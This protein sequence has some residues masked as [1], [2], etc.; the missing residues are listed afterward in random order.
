MLLIAILT[1][2][3]SRKSNLNI[4]EYRSA[5][6][7]KIDTNTVVSDSSKIQLKNKKSIKEETKKN[8]NNGDIVIKGKTD[9]T[10][11]FRFHNVVDGDTLSEIFIHGNADFV[12]KNRWNKSEKS[13]IKEVVEEKLN[14]VAKV[15]RKVVAQ[16]TIKEAAKEIKQIDKQ[17]NSK[18]FTFG[19]WF[20]Y[21]LIFVI[22]ACLVWLWFYFG[23]G[24]KFLQ[25]FKK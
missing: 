1:A 7:T 11:D 14:I 21:G 20:T 25:M 10:D 23:G 24:N 13:H 5:E 15:A 18:S 8:E 4:T 17:V 16:S 12:I 19:A 6:V 2:C 9:S 3:R 22:V